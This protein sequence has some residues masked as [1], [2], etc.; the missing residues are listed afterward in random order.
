MTGLGRVVRNLTLGLV[1]VGV[2]S[3]VVALALGR[4]DP[5]VMPVDADAHFPPEHV[6][7]ATHYANLKYSYW[8]AGSILRWGTFAGIVALGGGAAIAAAGRRGTRG[9]SFPTAFVAS[10]LILGLVAMA[11]LPVA[12]Q[13]GWRTERGFGLTS[14]SAAGWLFDWTREQAFWIVVYSALAAGFLAVLARWPRRGWMVAAGAGCLLA[15]AGLFLAP[16]V[17]DPLFHDFA[18]LEDRELAREIR[19]LGARAG[20]DIRRVVVMDAS[21]RTSRLNAYVT[22]LGATHQVV[23][24]DNLLEQAP[25]PEVLAVVAHEIGHTAAHHLR[26]GLLWS[27]PL[28]LVGAWALSALARLQARERGLEG[29]GD[30]AGLPLLWLALS[31]GL[32]F[33]SP[34]LNS[35]QRTME[36]EA[37]WTSLELTRDPRT[38]VETADRLT[39]ANLMP[40]DPPRWIVFWLYTHPPIRDRLGM[41][42]H[43]SDRNGVRLEPPVEPT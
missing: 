28:I 25:R 32:F 34:A 14:Q 22:G 37:D 30:P 35:I 4:R 43:W 5:R 8:A 2:A 13:S 42:R 27:I 26:K 19:A 10:V 21:R 18:P 11:G 36:S 33:V 29:P 6:D 9:R 17:I 20:I 12:F 38:Y 1:G 39:R 24:Y 15:M 3:V 40:I 7:L 23:L 16:R 41:A 31:L